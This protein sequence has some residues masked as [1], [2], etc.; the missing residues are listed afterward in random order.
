M[1]VKHR[2]VNC[3]LCGKGNLVR[4]EATNYISSIERWDNFERKSQ[5]WIGLDKFGNVHSSVYWEHG[6]AGHCVCESCKT[7]LCNAT[8]LEQAKKRQKML[9]LEQCLKR[10]PLFLGAV[11]KP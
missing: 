4:N 7:T 5:L 2:D 6:N 10:I 9:E 8:K 11:L 1:E 3:I